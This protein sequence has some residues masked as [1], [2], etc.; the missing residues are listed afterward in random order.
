MSSFLLDSVWTAY[1]PLTS[2]V[3]DSK[4]DAAPMVR[5]TVI[6]GLETD[7][8]ELLKHVA[9]KGGSTVHVYVR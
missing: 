6:V 2:H 5:A 8:N 1:Y 3:S 7:A 4:F 9:V